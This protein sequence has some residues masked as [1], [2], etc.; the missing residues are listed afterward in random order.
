MTLDSSFTTA[1]Y[2]EFVCLLPGAPRWPLRSYT[3]YNSK[4]TAPAEVATTARKKSTCRAQH[5][6][7]PSG[8]RTDE[9]E[10][11]THRS[12]GTRPATD[13]P[14]SAGNIPELVAGNW[15]TRRC[16]YP[17][18][19]GDICRARR[20][21]IRHC[22]PALPFRLATEDSRGFLRLATRKQVQGDQP[23]PSGIQLQPERT[24]P[25]EPPST[26]PPVPAES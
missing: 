4:L 2:T 5:V 3:A 11:I 12:G 16:T 18:G 23:T 14:T 20:P 1:E 22:F 10:A 19:G 9:Q 15:T 6:A 17:N 26:A 7:R 8:K 25:A 13:K 24:P 21:S